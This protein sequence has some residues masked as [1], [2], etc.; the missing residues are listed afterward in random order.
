MHE[1]FGEFKNIFKEG[2]SWEKNHIERCMQNESYVQHFLEDFKLKL[3]VE[4][5]TDDTGRVNLFKEFDMY[6]V[7]EVVRKNIKDYMSEKGFVYCEHNH[8]QGF[9]KIDDSV[10][11]NTTNKSRVNS[12]YAVAIPEKLN[13]SNKQ[14]T[15]LDNEDVMDDFLVMSKEDFLETYPYVTPQEYDM[16]ISKREYVEE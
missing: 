9:S 12:T 2:D 7:P 13:S 3:N 4:K 1:I 11:I 10:S 8:V 14:K 15:F 5:F 6:M 16:E